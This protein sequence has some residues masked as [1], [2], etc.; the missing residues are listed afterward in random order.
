M[1]PS[2]TCHPSSPARRPST[3]TADKEG[4]TGLLHQV[5]DIVGGRAIDSEPQ[6]RDLIWIEVNV[7]GQRNLDLRPGGAQKSVIPFVNQGNSD[8]LPG[9]VSRTRLA[10]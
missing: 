4:L 7:M 9:T 10:L 3:V 1:T 5:R 2:T 8:E 6:Q